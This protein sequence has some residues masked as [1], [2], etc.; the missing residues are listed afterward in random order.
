LGWRPTPV[1]NQYYVRR[2]GGAATDAAS[3]QQARDYRWQCRVRWAGSLQTQVYCRNHTWNVGQPASFDVE[4]AAPS[5]V[6][7]VLG[8]LGSCLAMG[9]Q[10]HAS[11]QGIRIDELELSLGGQIDNIYVFLGIEQAGHSG[12]HHITG[13]LY[14]RSDADAEVLQDLWQHTLAVSP[15]TQTLTRETALDIAIQHI[16]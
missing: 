16:P 12:F 13:T 2:G 14:V 10:I 8:A 4:D 11:R 1:D 5:A 15:V 6:E 9:F 3:E 7:Y